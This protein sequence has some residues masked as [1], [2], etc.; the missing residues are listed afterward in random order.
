MSE[1]TN[2]L[3][4]CA[5]GAAQGKLTTNSTD[6]RCPLFHVNDIDENAEEKWLVTGL[7]PERGRA[8]F[9]GPPKVGKTWLLTDLAVALASGQ[10]FLGFDV[11]APVSVLYVLAEGSKVRWKKRLSALTAGRGAN[12]VLP[13][14]VMPTDG[15]R[16]LDEENAPLLA[17]R[18]R[19]SGSSVVILDP[20]AMLSSADENKASEVAP[21]LQRLD[22]LIADTGASV[23]LVH[24]LRKPSNDRASS[25]HDL[26]GSGVFRAWPDLIVGIDKR[27]SVGEDVTLRLVVEGRDI[28]LVEPIE[29]RRA[30]K[31]GDDGAASWKHEV[32]RDPSTM[33]KE[34]GYDRAADRVLAALA[35]ATAAGQ[36]IRK[37]TALV[38]YAKMNKKAGL[39]AAKKLLATGKIID[40]P[41]AGLRIASPVS[42]SG[43]S[44]EGENPEPAMTRPEGGSTSPKPD[45]NRVKPE[46]RDA[47][48]AP[49]LKAVP[50]VH[51]PAPPSS[52]AP[53]DASPRTSSDVLPE[54]LIGFSEEVQQHF[55]EERKQLAGTVLVPAATREALKATLDWLYAEK[56]Y[57]GHRVMAYAQTW[58]RAREMLSKDKALITRILAQQEVLKR[59]AS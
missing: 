29:I 13:I 19:E 36:I 56:L 26:R 57:E 22:A 31:P 25:L 9:A 55:L 3:P 8:I 7:L 18:V 37:P 41:V 1:T 28:E 6:G 12:T 35:E 42:G 39:A 2:G 33:P 30:H 46:P 43:F 4:P 40:D 58:E 21:M 52:P 17:S 24:H 10:P 50:A 20:L 11:P 5:G 59:R 14:H 51:S 49:A 48:P 34:E 32:I 53:A 45:G 54:E 15:V 47:A 27:A 23:V 38:A 16:L 44:Q